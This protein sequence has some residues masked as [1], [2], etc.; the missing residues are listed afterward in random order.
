MVFLVVFFSG[1][2]VFFPGNFTASSFLTCYVNIAIFAGG[3]SLLGINT[4]LDS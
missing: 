4:N 3:F 1:F 2:D